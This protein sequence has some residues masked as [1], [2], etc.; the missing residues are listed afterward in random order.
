[1]SA[2][3]VQLHRLIERARLESVRRN[4]D[5]V[6]PDVLQAAPAGGHWTVL[7]A[8]GRLWIGCWRIASGQPGSFLSELRFQG[9]EL[10]VDVGVACGLV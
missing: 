3:D 9:G 8:L 6:H 4:R 2:N 5:Q 7:A 1:M 10:A